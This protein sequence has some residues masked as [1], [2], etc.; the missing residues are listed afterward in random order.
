MQTC[1]QSNKEGGGEVFREAQKRST[2]VLEKEENENQEKNAPRQRT[3]DKYKS[4]KLN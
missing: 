1:D 2:M 3:L 4:R